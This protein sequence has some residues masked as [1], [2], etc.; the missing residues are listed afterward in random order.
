MLSD[1]CRDIKN[2]F[3]IGNSRVHKLIPTFN[4]KERYVLHEKK[5]G[6]LFESWSPVKEGTSCPTI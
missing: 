6:A 4:D 5:F 1:Y 3:E 2:K